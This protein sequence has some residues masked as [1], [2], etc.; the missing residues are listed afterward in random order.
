VLDGDGAARAVADAVH[1]RLVAGLAALPHT[2]LFDWPGCAAELGRAALY[3]PGH[4]YAARAPPAASAPA[5]VAARLARTLRPLFLPPRKCLVLDLDDTLWGGVL[6]D[7]GVEGVALGPEGLGRAF[8]DFQRAVA[9]LARRGVLLAVASKNDETH[10]LA[11][12]GEHP[13]G[14]LRPDDFSAVR[15][16]WQEKA[17]SLREIAAAL[18]IGLDA[19][20]FWDDSPVERHLV[21]CAL[22]EVLVVDVPADPTRAVETLRALECFDATAVTA[23][24]R[25]RA[26]MVRQDGARAA[27]RA[28]AGTLAD[29]LGGLEM[30]AVV[31]RP[32]EAE[33]ARVAQLVGKTNQFNLTTRRH[34]EPALRALDRAGVLLALTLSDRF[35]PAGLVAVAGALRDGGPDGDGARWRLDTFVMSCRAIGREVE[36]ALLGCLARRVR[37]R[38]GRHLRG[39]FLPTARNAVAADFLPRAGFVPGGDGH[40]ALDLGAG[41]PAPP[42]CVAVTER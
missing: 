1:A 12:L 7:V 18:H 10:A 30:R 22:P 32:A 29:Y 8:T 20:V 4:W 3:A 35:G 40:L 17:A 9:G 34:G 15:I 19:L 37:A 2:H 14:V 23:E 28:E 27:L 24:D 6:G 31:G 36:H 25:T 42:A 38:G 16:G 11:A 39:E 13:H 5:P 33:W 21:G 26:A 41:P